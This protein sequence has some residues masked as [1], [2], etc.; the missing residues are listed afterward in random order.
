MNLDFIR[1]IDKLFG[2]V[3]ACMLCLYIYGKRMFSCGKESAQIKKILIV[4]FF[5]FGNLVLAFPTIKKISELFPDAKICLLTINKNK[6]LYDAVDFVDKTVYINVYSVKDF[7]FSLLR[8]FFYLRREKFDMAVD[9]EIYAYI[10]TFIIYMCGIKKR[11]GYRMKGYLRSPLYTTAVEYNDNQH[12]TRTFYDLAV[13]LGAEKKEQVELIELHGS[14]KDRD[15]VG[16]FL[17]KNAIGKR[18]RLVGIHVGSGENFINRRWPERNFARV[19]DHLMENYHAKIL[20]TGTKAERTLIDNTIKEME[21]DKNQV[22]VAD[23][24]N[25]IQ[26]A[27][28][29][30]QCKIYFCTDT[31]PLHLAIAMGVPTIS[32][33]GPNTPRLYGPPSNKKHL[34][35][36]ENVS[37]S[38]CITNYNAKMSKCQK[39]ICLTNISAQRVIDT[40]NVFIKECFN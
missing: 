27:Y 25:L 21:S 35:F 30:K 2:H 20:F 3:I 4:R 11:V 5:G 28:L 12:I 40:L 9:F 15:V 6:H 19:A 26:L 38:P 22:V 33:F 18:D 7:V 39:P 13:T 16:E 1:I 34:Y 10:S 32:F 29:I 36:Y 24:F 14:E 31:G 23:M 37:C 17:S 8:V